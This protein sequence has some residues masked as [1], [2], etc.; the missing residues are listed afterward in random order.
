MNIFDM[1]Y[2]I[3]KYN[4]CHVYKLNYRCVFIRSNLE[5]AKKTELKNNVSFE[6]HA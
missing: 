2:G 3:N 1:V 5:A 4:D 6:Y